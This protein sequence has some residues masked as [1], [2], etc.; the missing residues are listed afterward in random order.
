MEYKPEKLYYF[1][2]FR[3]FLL[4]KQ[5]IQK[6]DDKF[7]TVAKPQRFP[8]NI[9]VEFLLQ[10]FFER[11]K[12]YKVWNLCNATILKKRDEVF[13]M[14]KLYFFIIFTDSNRK[15]IYSTNPAQNGRQY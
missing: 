6:I 9:I 3:I 10:I 14:N 15:N 1:K 13:S 5:Y 7:Q 4:N 8:A 12:N 2:L 11:E